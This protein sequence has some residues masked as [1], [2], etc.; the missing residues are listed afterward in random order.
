MQKIL[1]QHRVEAILAVTYQTATQ[2]IHKR[3]YKDCP[4]RV[5]E[6]SETTVY[7]A[8]EP[9]A[10]QNAVRCFG[11]R[12]YV[13]N[14]LALGLNEAVLAYREQYL[15]ERG[16]GRY[17][18]KVLELT[19]LYLSVEHRIKGL[20]RLLS[21]GLRLL[22]LLEYSVRTAHDEKGEKLAGIY[23]GNPKRATANPTAE[24]IL[25]AFEWIHLREMDIDG[26]KLY[27]VSP[28]SAVQERIL[29]LLGFPATIYQALSG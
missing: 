1:T 29:L 16:F 13:S 18:G 28:L 8:I 15:I 21:I 14:D 23:R 7:S 4:A 6:K 27:T 25:K 17:K 20:V 12:V 2:T 9:L 10:Y 11:W 3:A 5:E 22:C 26:K 24:M 19:P